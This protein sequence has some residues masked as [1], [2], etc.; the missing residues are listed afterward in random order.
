MSVTP[1]RQATGRQ[2]HEIV[3]QGAVAHA[4]FGLRAGVGMEGGDAPA[5]DR[6][7]VNRHGFG[8]CQ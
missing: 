6:G 4:T 3:T 2:D 1:S 8:S 7:N 5:F